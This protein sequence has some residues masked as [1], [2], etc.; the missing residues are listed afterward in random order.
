M[1]SPPP[2]RSEFARRFLSGRLAELSTH[3]SANFVV[4]AYLAELSDEA[5]VD[6]ALEELGPTVGDLL[7]S[8]RGGVVAALVAAAARLPECQKGGAKALAR[9]LMARFGGGARAAPRTKL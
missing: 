2:L 9:G 3:P 5:E 1:E 8:S 6:A 4:Q 7:A